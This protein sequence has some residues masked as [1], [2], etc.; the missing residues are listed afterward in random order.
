MGIVHLACGAHRSQGVL[1]HLH[2]MALRDSP[3]PDIHEPG[4]PEETIL[5]RGV[6]VAVRQT[7]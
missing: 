1:G 7:P 4:V 5:V 2:V 6:A 3:D